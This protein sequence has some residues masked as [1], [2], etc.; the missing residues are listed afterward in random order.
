MIHQLRRPK[1]GLLLIAPERF[2]ALGEGTKRGS[3]L[4]RKQAEAAW[5]KA[6]CEKTCDVSFP[7][8]VLNTEDTKRAID[9]F[10]ADKVDFVLAIYLSWAEDYAYIR[11]LRDMP[12]CPVLFAHRMR[13]SIGLHD[14]HDDDEFTEYLCCGGLVGM[15]EASGNNA[16]YQRPLLETY[17]GT[18]AQI[19]ERVQPFAA[20]ARARA[21]LKDAKIGL[22][23]CYNEAMWSTY[24]HPYDVFRFVGP[25]LKFLSIAELED[26]VEA[27]PVEEAKGVMQ[28]IA[29]TYEVKPDVAEDK[30]LAS[31]R[32]TMGMER[33]GKAYGVDLLVLNDIDTMLFK[34]I[35]LRPGFYPTPACDDLVIVP[36]GDLG[37]GIATYMLRLLTNDH[38]NFI[39]PF[40]IDLPENNFAAGHAGPNDY[41]DPR[42]KTK[43]SRDVRFAKSQWKYAGAPFAWYVFPEGRKTMLHCSEHNGKF[44]FAATL[45]DCLPTEHFLAT[46]S[47]GLFRAVGETN[48][49]LFDKLLKLGVTQHYGLVAGDCIPAVEDLAKMLDFDY[50]RV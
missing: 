9:L 29:D 37:A 10:T 14:T 33:M 25:E 3:Y 44:M 6:D 21:I 50:H 16:N 24:V 46:Y 12:P 28:Q 31:V 27:V 23:A 19:M 8:I 43:V 41:S 1:M 45:L 20:A 36:E 22:L 40:H 18:W 49:E 17:I 2:C 35:G 30:F 11:F 15:Q 13:D 39:E 4:A 48:V 5:M 34:K 7:G 47:H 42:G 38:V 32:A 26:F